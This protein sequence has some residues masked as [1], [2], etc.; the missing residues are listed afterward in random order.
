MRSLVALSLFALLLGIPSVALA[1]RF[2][3]FGNEPQAAVPGWPQ[4]LLEVVNLRSRVY[5]L[6]GDG[7]NI[8]YFRGNAKDLQEALEKFARI[9]E[10][11]C[12]LFLLPGP[13]QT[14]SFNGR[15]IVFN[16]QLHLGIGGGRPGEVHEATSCPAG[17]CRCSRAAS[18][19]GGCA[20]H[21]ALVRRAG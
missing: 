1:L 3:S 20:D 15:T 10:G 13:A 9:K 7:P 21:P 18:F 12:Q 16:W 17:L 19:D 8:C 4:G 6:A 5:F 2:E 11:K 14:H